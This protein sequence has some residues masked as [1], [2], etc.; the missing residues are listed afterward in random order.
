M[1][2]CAYDEKTDDFRLFKSEQEWRNQITVSG[3]KRYLR[4]HLKKSVINDFTPA[5]EA[6]LKSSGV[7]KG[8]FGSLRILFPIITFLGTLLKGKDEAKNA[9]AFMEKY[10]GKVNPLYEEL[11]DLIYN[12]YRHGLI[13][14]QMPKLVNIDGWIIGWMITYTDAEHLNVKIN[15]AQKNLQIPVCA[16]VLFNDLLKAIDLY[17]QDFEDISRQ[18]ELLKIF[19]DGFVSMTKVF[20]KNSKEVRSSTKALAYLRKLVVGN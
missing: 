12:V 5:M 3:V 7:G 14:T 17:I 19:K 13:H 2:L 6:Y 9:I 8:F 11:S 16:R 18:A 1:S 20:D 4:E 10:L 15:S